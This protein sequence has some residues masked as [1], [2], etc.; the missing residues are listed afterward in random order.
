[1]QG[2]ATQSFAGVPIPSSGYVGWQFN[3][4]YSYNG[5]INVGKW[6]TYYVNGDLVAYPT[7]TGFHVHI[8]KYCE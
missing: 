1:M 5:Q 8:Y 3:F 2:T 4:D 7:G 6:L